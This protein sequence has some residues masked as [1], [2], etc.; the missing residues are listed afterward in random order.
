MKTEAEAAA[1]RPQAKEPRRSQELEEA[2]RTLP[3]G[4]RG[5]MAR[6]HLDFRLLA[7]RTG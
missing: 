3:C 6:G 4:S 5:S 2:G 1:M 7:F